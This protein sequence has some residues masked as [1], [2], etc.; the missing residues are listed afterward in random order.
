M[1]TFIRRIIILL[2]LFSMV[3]LVYRYINPIGASK[4]VDKIKSISTSLWISWSTDDE[5]NINQDDDIVLE[6]W[7]QEK[8]QTWNDENFSW[9]EELNKEIEN[10]L[11]KTWDTTTNG[12]QTWEVKED[13]IDELAMG[14]GDATVVDPI[15]TWEQVQPQTTTTT[16]KT[17][18]KWGDCGPWFTQ[19]DCDDMKNVFGNLVE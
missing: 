6:T 19:K 7:D 8:L 1:G 9:L 10:I 5:Y 11:W 3:F 4:F 15:S 12:Q 2:I 16:T 18:I 17:N 14:T 13:N